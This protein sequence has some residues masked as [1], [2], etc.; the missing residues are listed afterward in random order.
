MKMVKKIL[1]FISIIFILFSCTN[2]QKQTEKQIQTVKKESLAVN[3]LKETDTI[4]VNTI[5]GKVMFKN[6][7]CDGGAW[8]PPEVITSYEQETPLSNSTILLKNT[9]SGNK[10]IKIT[11]D[12]KGNFSAQ[13]DPGTYNYF[14]TK[15]FDQ[16]IGADFDVSD[17]L[18]YNKSFGKIKVTE[19]PKTPI[20]IIF[21]FNR[22][23]F[24]QRP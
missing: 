2:Q 7:Y 8:A 22:C 14:M 4:K 18:I 6:K 1:L 24:G 23:G 19:D 20:K 17:G 21:H 9:V 16:T 11:T 13:I 10:S 5:S 3:P 12:K 15:S